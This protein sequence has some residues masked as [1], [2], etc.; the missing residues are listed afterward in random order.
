MVSS[1][2]T[3]KHIQAINLRQEA[4]EAA[5]KSRYSFGSNDEF[6]Q[7]FET[8]SKNADHKTV[9]V[10]EAVS[11]PVRNEAKITIHEK[12]SDSRLHDHE[13]SRSRHH[14]HDAD[15][16]AD[17]KKSEGVKTSKTHLVKKEKT[18]LD[19]AGHCGNA[20]DEKTCRDIS[21]DADQ[22]IAAVT[23]TSSTPKDIQNADV[24]DDASGNLSHAE[25]G[26]DEAA[27]D[28]SEY[29]GQS[30][31]SDSTGDYAEQAQDEPLPDK[32]LVLNTAQPEHADA[33]AKSSDTLL[34][35]GL[36]VPVS[37]HHNTKFIEADADHA[38]RATDATFQKTTS[39]SKA[40]LS[41]TTPN[42]ALASDADDTFAATVDDQAVSEK[43]AQNKET[44][45]TAKNKRANTK[46]ANEK[47]AEHIEL[48]QSTFSADP[49]RPAASTRAISA[50]L[51]ASDSSAPTIN[52]P[53][54]GGSPIAAKD[55]GA[56]PAATSTGGLRQGQTEQSSFTAIL[57]GTKEAQA[58]HMIPSEQVAVHMHRM[59]KGGS[60]QYEL[61]LHPAELGRVD[62]RLE[63]NKD[64]AVQATVTA[65]NQ[66]TF[67]MLQKDSRSLERA[68][69]QAG[70]QTDSNSLS[71]NLRG[72]NSHAQQHGQNNPAHAWN[73]WTDK[74][75]PEETI[76]SKI[77]TYDV[78]VAA[79]RI[80]LRV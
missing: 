17:A 61:Q 80:D 12:K 75:I 33:L 46:E 27:Q 42:D 76:Q 38:S 62:I 50:A 36:A 40:T 4:A 34:P 44:A 69:Q 30:D 57:R 56:N 29:M 60:N 8:I 66:Q 67:D 2:D 51:T 54:G 58:S 49:T 77:L 37:T 65:D 79:G 39:A 28:I 10:K 53:A 20:A 73:K 5:F 24:Q 74:S 22:S 21:E 48:L 41:D 6:K 26:A 47:H 11:E 1:S 59:A 78:G 19:Q 43:T 32:A 25:F 14:H 68:L 72:Q 45:E 3:A 9:D 23:A 16:K 64:G 70:L 15:A 52:G 71:F 31:D 7:I 35:A 18:Q 13:A 63:I 55:D